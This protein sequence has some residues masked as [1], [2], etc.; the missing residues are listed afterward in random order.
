MQKLRENEVSLLRTNIKVLY[1]VLYQSML[2]AHIR[3]L[4]FVTY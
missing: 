4:S 1:Y 3:V 2:I